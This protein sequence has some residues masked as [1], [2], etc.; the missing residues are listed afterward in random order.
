MSRAP[1]RIYLVRHGQTSWNAEGRAQGHTDIPLDETGTR[2][3]ERVAEALGTAGAT[4]VWSSDLSR[5]HA[6]ASAV[7]RSGSLPLRVFPALR[8]RC[9][10]DWEGQPLAELRR[11]LDAEARDRGVAASLVR[12]PGG[13]SLA[14]AWA[15]V[16][17]V[18]ATLTQEPAE[19]ASVV[20]VS[21]GAISSLLLAQLIHGTL[22]TA[23][24][25]RP[26]NASITVL[27]RR[28]GGGLRLVRYDDVT[29][30]S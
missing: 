17:P 10:G 12:P 4:S 11:R 15:R 21:H 28:E 1:S 16:E 14:D 20:V 26:Q 3:A 13:E 8:E 6:T 27:E 5:S 25:F 24:S 29:H 2:Q 22:E 7:A 30:L 9:F 18:A 23:R 19:G